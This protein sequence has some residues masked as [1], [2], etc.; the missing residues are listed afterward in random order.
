MDKL[1]WQINDC[2]NSWK[3]FQ[4]FA[5]AIENW[6]FQSCDPD[7]WYSQRRDT[8]HPSISTHWLIAKTNVHN[9]NVFPQDDSMFS[10]YVLEEGFVCNK[11][12]NSG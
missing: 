7:F 9:P 8:C 10:H 4:H 2:S 1:G 11:L 12:W 5:T 3:C 6:K